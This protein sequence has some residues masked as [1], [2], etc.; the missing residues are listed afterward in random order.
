MKSLR[1]ILAVVCLLGSTSLVFGAD[2][3]VSSTGSN[4]NTVSFCQRSTPCATF[5]AAFSVT[6]FGG[7]IHVLDAGAFGILTITHGVTLDGGNLGTTLNSGGAGES[8]APQITIA[9]GSTD[10]VT[11]QNLT[12][13]TGGSFASAAIAVTRVGG[14]HVQNCTFS[15]YRNAAIDFR[16]TGAQLEM[17]NV[18]ITDIQGG[19]GVYVAN[20]RGVLDGVHIHHTQTAVLAAGSS[21]V[22]IRRSTV[23]GNGSG[24]VA[25]YG[26]TAEIHVD[27]C[28]MTNNQ[29]AV[30]VASGARAYVS[31]SSLFNNFITAMFNDDGSSLISYGNNQFAGNANDGTFTSTVSV[32]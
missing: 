20:A 14:L 6:D 27:D 18:T 30:V 1:A 8:S 17:T 23:N 32:K 2:T 9:A 10:I 22:S 26:P 3:Y 11:I 12:I 28:V 13:S 7:V 29:W 15:G 16:A 4:A 5:S 21:T 24:F 19:V 31:R 25:A